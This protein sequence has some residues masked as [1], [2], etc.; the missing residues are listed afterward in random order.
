MAEFTDSSVERITNITLALLMKNSK[1][2]FCAWYWMYRVYNLTVFSYE[3]NFQF[4]IKCCN[5][6]TSATH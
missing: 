3:Q 2:C 1:I 5:I 6:G 4:F